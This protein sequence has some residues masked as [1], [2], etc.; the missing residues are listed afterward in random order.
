MM[1]RRWWFPIVLGSVALAASLTLEAVSGSPT[2]PFG[3]P[4]V[5]WVWVV[6]FSGLL[7]WRWT[8]RDWRRRNLML[9]WEHAPQNVRVIHMD[10]SVTPC[11]IAYVGVVEGIHTWRVTTHLRPHFG[12]RLVVDKMSPKTALSMTST[13]ARPD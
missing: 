5:L 4:W 8:V 7:A 13:I 2:G 9:P 10:G 1:W 11:E 6:I 3:V 12:D